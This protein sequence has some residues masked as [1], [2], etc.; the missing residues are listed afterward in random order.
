M[1]MV[2]FQCKM[3]CKRGDCSAREEGRTAASVHEVRKIT[4]SVS[5]TLPYTSGYLLQ[6]Q[7]PPRGAPMATPA[8]TPWASSGIAVGVAAGPPATNYD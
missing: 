3:C 1:V 7:L 2:I 5:L 4:P 6:P 8:D